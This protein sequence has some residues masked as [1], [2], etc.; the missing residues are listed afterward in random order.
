MPR[1]REIGV[2]NFC[3]RLPIIVFLAHTAPFLKKGAECSQQVLPVFGIR[4]PL[5]SSC[6]KLQGIVPD[7]Y[8]LAASL[9]EERGQVGG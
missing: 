1:A 7:L 6:S 3:E 5:G 9:T 4:Q 2:P 8:V